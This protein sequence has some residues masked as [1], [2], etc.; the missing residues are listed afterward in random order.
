[1]KIEEIVS[2]IRQYINQF[3]DGERI[4]KIKELQHA[5]AFELMWSELTDEEREYVRNM[6]HITDEIRKCLD[7]IKNEKQREEYVNG[8]A[9]SE[10]IKQLEWD[11]YLFGFS[12]EKPIVPQKA[13]QIVDKH[14]EP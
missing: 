13:S 14:L 6:P 3:V 2:K 12:K 10:Y 11:N 8:L 7:S 5:L 1:M 4:E 9:T